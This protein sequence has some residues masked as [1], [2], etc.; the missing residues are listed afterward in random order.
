MAFVET[1]RDLTLTIS[2]DVTNVDL[3]AIAGGGSGGFGSAGGG[4][5]AGGLFYAQN[6]TLVAGIYTI[7]IG[8]GGDSTNVDRS[9]NANTQ[10]SP[11]GQDT[12][13]HMSHI[14]DTFRVRGGGGSP[15]AACTARNYNDGIGSGIT[16]N[17]PGSNGGSGGGGSTPAWSTSDSGGQ[18]VGGSTLVGTC[19]GIV[20][21][22]TC[23]SSFFGGIGGTLSGIAGAAGG[24]WHRGGAG[25]KLRQNALQCSNIFHPLKLTINI[26]AVSKAGVQ[27]A[28]VFHTW[29]APTRSL[30]MLGTL[31]PK[32]AQ[33]ARVNLSVSQEPGFIGQAVAEA[34]ATLQT[35]AGP[36]GPK[37]EA[38]DRVS[39]SFLFF[40]F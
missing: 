28:L 40:S 24:A 14:N 26:A 11:N 25:G 21:A 4:G 29:A 20:S 36:A 22:S 35:T 34:A 38:A 31:W 7:S 16:D 3:L 33:A 1:G 17:R 37:L 39:L 30:A 9:C 13:I 19:A 27:V 8:E 18:S 12:T 2:E 23:I 6:L 5:G 32:N 10:N 15:I